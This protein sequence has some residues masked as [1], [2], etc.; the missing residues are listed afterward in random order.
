MSPDLKQIAHDS[1]AAAESGAQTFPQIVGR[2]IA[3][4]FEGYQVDLRAGTATYYLPSGE[5]V[6]VRAGSPPSADAPRF[7][8]D[9]VI[10]AIREAQQDAPGYTYAGFCEKVA[11]AGCVGYL[12]SFPGRRVVYLGRTG[13]THT[14]HFP[15]RGADTVTPT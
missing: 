6:A 10:S 3:A 11:R 14:E 13:E 5:A 2:L 4:G 9:A 12:V 1:I 15:S 7:D 8:A